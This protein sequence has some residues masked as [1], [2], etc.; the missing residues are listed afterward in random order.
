MLSVNKNNFQGIGGEAANKDF[1]SQAWIESLCEKYPCEKELEKILNRKLRR[2]VSVNFSPV[3]LETLCDGV[4]KLL[5][6]QLNEPFEIKNPRWLSGGASK[7]QMAFDLER[8]SPQGGATLVPLV[9]R[10][11]P[12]ASIVETSRLREFQLLAEMKGVVPVPEVFAVDP[13]GD[14]FPYPALICGFAKGVT[15]PSD[16][17]SRVSGIGVTFGNQFRDA[18]GRQFVEHLAKIHTYDWRGENLGA[19]DI[20]RINS[21]QGVEWKINLWQRVWEEDAREEIPLLTFVAHWLRKNMPPIDHVS[22]LHGDYRSGNFLFDEESLE[23]TAW[24]DW[25]GGHLG[26]R[27]D[28]LAYA[29][30]SSW[31]C[32]SEDGKSF[33]VCG[34]M[35][36]A[37]FYE[38]YEKASGLSVDKKRLDYYRI[39]NGYKMCCIGLATAYRA[40]AGGK[41][42]QD[43]ALTHATAV[44][45]PILDDLRKTLEAIV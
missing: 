39:F 26:D 43:I 22:I 14:F 6:V 15:K 40:V 23:I 32:R 35:P 38:R 12:A 45:Y 34:F 4:G 13:D 33:L 8:R 30:Y 7:M 9:L 20:P 28:D 29:A 37:E 25:E 18:L 16:A 1:P 3:S 42:H 41:T 2:R 21:N 24:L 44:C 31:G 11:E 10:M 5:A 36:E 17:E 27:H 19:F